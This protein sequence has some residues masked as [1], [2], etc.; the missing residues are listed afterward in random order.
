MPF[1][2]YLAL[3]PDSHLHDVKQAKN[4]SKSTYASA[5]QA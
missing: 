1:T 5:P 2:Y 3:R 4:T